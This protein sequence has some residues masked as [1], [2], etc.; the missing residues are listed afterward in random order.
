MIF[1]KNDPELS[2]YFSDTGV[3]IDV[4]DNRLVFK[5]LNVLEDF[6]QRMKNADIDKL[7]IWSQKFNFE[8]FDGVYQE[9]YKNGKISDISFFQKIIYQ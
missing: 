3:D 1:D 9:L 4:K 7:N 5:D 6:I 2:G 8:N